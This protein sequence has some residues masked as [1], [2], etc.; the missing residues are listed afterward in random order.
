MNRKSIKLYMHEFSSR[1]FINPLQYAVVENFSS[2][3]KLM[4]VTLAEHCEHK[5]KKLL[6]CNKHQS[7]T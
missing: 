7:L 3:V 6:N 1:D 4:D 2:M 5:Q